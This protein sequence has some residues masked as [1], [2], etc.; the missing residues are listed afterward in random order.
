MFTNL[1]VKADDRHNAKK[2]TL[3]HNCKTNAFVT[4]I[5]AP[6]LIRKVTF[7]NNSTTRY[8]EMCSFMLTEV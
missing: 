6:K 8:F 1:K 2:T 7:L 4:H 5:Y 3:I